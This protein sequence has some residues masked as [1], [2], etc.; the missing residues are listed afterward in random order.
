MWYYFLLLLIHISI[1]L[2]QIILHITRKTTP[3]T[4]APSEDS[5][6]D[7]YSDSAAAVVHK[8]DVFLSFR[9]ADT[10]GN[11]TSHLYAALSG[12]RVLTYIDDVRLQ[13][14]DEISDT[15][16]KAI[17]ESKMAVVVFSENYADSGWCLDELV[18]IMRCRKKYKQV[19][20]PV[21]FR[22]DPSD[23]AEQKRSY[24]AAMSKHGKSALTRGKVKMWRKALEGAADL[25]GWDSLNR[26]DAVLVRTIVTNILRTL[27]EMPPSLQFTGLVGAETRLKKIKSLLDTDS[28]SDTRII[29]IWGMG[30]MGKTT[31]ARAIFDQ[32]SNEFDGSHFLADIRRQLGAGSTELRLQQELFSS[33]LDDHDLDA[34]S[35]TKVATTA[36][37]KNR[38]HRTK[39]LVVLDDVDESI[40]LHNLLDKQ[41]RTVFGPGSRI[42]VTSR[43]HQVLK[44]VCNEIYEV[45]KLDD[46]ES[47][48][49]FLSNAFTNDPSDEFKHLSREVIRY[50]AGHP[51]AIIVF[52]KNLKDRSRDYWQS[53]L[54]RLQRIPNERIQRMLKTSFEKLDSDERNGFLDIACFFKGESKQYV[55]SRLDVAY[56]YGSSEY[57]IT[58]LADKSLVSFSGDDER[59]VMNSLMEE[60]GRGIVNEES[61][62][63]DEDDDDAVGVRSRLLLTNST[64]AP[65]LIEDVGE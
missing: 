40:T 57:I 9:G 21:F 22:V 25:S 31:L 16:L 33:I 23:V 54:F 45:E 50:T 55:K 37:S 52:G 14:G 35:Y 26:S 65:L 32:Y 17:E 51:L 3:T 64:V 29:G 47:C 42:V 18:Q 61:D 7:S 44:T 63:E 30:G 2:T 56:G 19:V 46:D 5:D 41:P 36:I 48:E 62:F 28:S 4:D 1:F 59:V 8:Y 27:N 20:Y 38:L 34:R 60:M 11:F 10:R 58:S 12:R 15:L 24:A 43:D 53:T 49:L 39:S 6:S 13:R